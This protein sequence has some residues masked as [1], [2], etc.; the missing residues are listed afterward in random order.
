MMSDVKSLKQAVMPIIWLNCLCCMGVFEMPIN[1]PRYFL[2]GFYVI[3]ILIGYFCLF[4]EEIYIF[5]KLPIQ[6]SL[7]FSFVVMGVNIVVAVLAII[8]FWCKSEKTNNIIKRSSIADSTLQALGIKLEYQKIHRNILCYVTVS[9]AIGITLFI[10]HIAWM[11][12]HVGYWAAVLSNICICFPAL[13]NSVVDLTFVSFIRCVKVKFENTN[14][15]IK[16]IMLSTNESNV[17]MTHNRYDNT[18]TTF[19]I[20]NYKNNK[21]KII[22]LI[23]TLRH[24]HLE[25][26]RIGRQINQAYCLQLLLELAV[27]FTMVTSTLYCIYGVFSNQLSVTIN[28]EEIIAL[29]MTAS[30]FSLKIIFINWICTNASTE[31]YKTGEIIQSFEGSI[32]DDDMREEIHQFT[33]QVV[34][35]SL[36]FT[37]TGF[38]SINNSLT[39]KFF[40]TVSTY[41]VILI[42]M[43]KFM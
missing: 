5:Q 31:A 35:N 13:I 21:D 11:F 8:L 23:Q 3:S 9:L 14:I 41:V 37:A 1:R 15:L 30:V 20:E 19:D 42:Q 2:S 36:N 39:G 33:L 28:N 6:A 16:N 27:H 26:T 18:S 34:L 22:H 7:I 17:F 4:Y 29:T 12:H 43:N 24:L 38:F 32:I 25:I 10:V 40:A